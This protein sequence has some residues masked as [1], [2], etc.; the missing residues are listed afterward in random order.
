MKLQ[1]IVMRESK[2]LNRRNKDFNCR[3]KSLNSSRK[4]CAI[5]CID[6]ETVIVIFE[7]CEGA[8]ILPITQERMNTLQVAIAIKA[9]YTTLVKELLKSMTPEQLA[10]KNN[11]GDTALAIAALSGDVK[12]AMEIV[13]KNNELPMIRNMEGI[14]PL[15]TAA[16]HKH[17]DMVVYL[18]SVT[19]FKKLDFAERIKL[20][21]CTISWDMY[22]TAYN[23]LIVSFRKLIYKVFTVI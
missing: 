16:T 8:A 14:L 11:N 21:L 15:L 20:L 12:T 18:Y 23:S 10:F 13:K 7:V 9:K 22:G 17:R 2:A 4:R 19:E 6:W 1:V 3:S 5:P